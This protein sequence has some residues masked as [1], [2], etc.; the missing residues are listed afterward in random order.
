[1]T[2]IINSTPWDIDTI[3]KFYDVAIAYQKTKFNKHWQ[4]FERL[5]IETEIAENRQYKIVVDG[6]IACV[7]AVTFN[8]AAIWGERDKEPSIYLHRI[9]TDN[10]FRGNDFVRKIAAWAL[11]YGSKT[12]KQFV[13]MDT[14]AD[15]EKLI[16][17]YQQCG[18]TFLGLTEEINAADLPKHYDSIRLSLFEMAIQPA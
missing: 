11:G 15:N 12:N 13:R 10:A 4:G 2:E 5:L 9:V 14:W 3:F 18:F 17:Y 6:V 16:A 1:M 8:D 7:F